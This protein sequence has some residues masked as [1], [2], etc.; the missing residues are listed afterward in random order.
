MA[1]WLLYPLAL[2]ATGFFT[3]GERRWLTTLRS[4]GVLV[5]Q[6]RSLRPAAAAVDGSVPETYEAEQMDEDSRL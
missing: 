6:L 3:P 5:A 2:L 4:P 1:L